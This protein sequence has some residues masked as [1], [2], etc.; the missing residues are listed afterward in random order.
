MHFKNLATTAALTSSSLA[1][2]ASGRPRGLAKRDTAITWGPL[3]GLGPTSGGIEIIS[4]ISTIYPG[5]MPSTQAGGLYNWI[6]INNETETGD[7]VQGIVGSYTHGQSECS[8]PDADKLWCVSAE[9]YG[10]NPETDQ[11]QQYVGEMTT[12]DTTP[13]DGVTFNYTLID[14]ETGLWLQCVQQ[15]TT[16]ST[17]PQLSC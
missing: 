12:L 5:N 16:V 6:G 4:V 2:A 10:V 14:R 15:S 3:I 13:S 11:Y 17:L 9:V 7:L 8:G 1:A